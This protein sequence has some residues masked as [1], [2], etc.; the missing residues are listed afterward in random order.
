VASRH[1]NDIASLADDA[2]AELKA[3][4]VAIV[5]RLRTYVASALEEGKTLDAELA[6][7]LEADFGRLLTELGYDAAVEDVLTRFEE[8]AARDEAHLADTLGT[9]FS[10]ANRQALGAFVNGVVD[11]LLQL[12][13]EAGAAVKAA[14]FVGAT[15][16]VDR[17]DLVEEVARAAEVTLNQ[18]LSEVDTSIMAFHRESLTSEAEDAGFDLGTY[19]GPDDGLTRPFCAEHM[20]GPG[21]G[22]I[23]TTRDLDAEDNGPEQ[24]KPVSR[25]LGG[26]RC[27]HSWNPITV[28][29]AKAL[30]AKHGERVV[31]GPEARRI[32]L[33]GAAGPNETAFVARFSGSVVTRGGRQ[34]VVRRRRRAA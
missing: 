28:E 3:A 12:K 6:A 26:Y 33:R 23:Y 21:V 8:V 32:V 9:S 29:E 10:S 19:D 1:A 5:R 22:R 11:E 15:T 34:K 16:H 25:F 31:G 7:K 14:V 18:A 27:R 24:P 20:L 30:V 4:I 13:D 2:I 17:A